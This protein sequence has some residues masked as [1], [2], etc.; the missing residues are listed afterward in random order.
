[1][2]RRLLF[3]LCCALPV[4]SLG[5]APEATAQTRIVVPPAK[6][7]KPAAPAQKT[8]PTPGFVV[9][10]AENIV[11]LIRSTLL[12]LNDAIET[13]NYTVLRDLAA[14]SFREANSAGRLYQIFASL[15]AQRV[16]L[17]AVTILAPKLPQP[18]SIDADG[19]LHITGFFPGEPV[20]INFE[21]TFEA[22]ANRWRIFGLSVTPVTSADA[23]LLS[24]ARPGGKQEEAAEQPKSGR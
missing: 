24:Q 22:V 1:L 19:R 11:I 4:F 21:L 18:P 12:S 7:S 20:H 2:S 17:A 5:S 16:N 3:L 15:A 23:G 6:D 13:G 14:P 9:P 10:S 8:L